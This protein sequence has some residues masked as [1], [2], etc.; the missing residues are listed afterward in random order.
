MVD[1]ALIANKFCD[2]CNSLLQTWQLRKH[3]FD[4]NEDID[5]LKNPNFGNLF[6]IIINSLQELWILKLVNLHDKVKFGD[7]YNLSL[8]YIINTLPFSK[9]KLLKLKNLKEN[10]D[11]FYISIKQAR[12]Q[13]I[14]HNDLESIILEKELGTFSENHD[15]QYFACLIEFADIISREFTGETFCYDDLIKNDVI[16][17]MHC[18]K[19]G[20]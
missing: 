9:D 7:K 20:N 12:N 13:I 17:F 15:E 14:S 19:K 11:I 2:I 18:I 1:N 8:Q 16:H 10:M 5:V 4:T 3:L 6:N